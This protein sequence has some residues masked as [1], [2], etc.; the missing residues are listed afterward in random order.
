MI[1]FSS[2]LHLDTENYTCSYKVTKVTCECSANNRA[3]DLSIDIGENVWVSGNI[4]R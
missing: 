4:S 1:D 2:C 3:T